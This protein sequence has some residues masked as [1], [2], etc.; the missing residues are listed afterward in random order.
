MVT[1][2]KPCVYYGI[3][4]RL[5]KDRSQYKIWNTIYV[6]LYIRRKELPLPISSPKSFPRLL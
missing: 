1:I 6:F 4:L 2:F 5:R 3:E